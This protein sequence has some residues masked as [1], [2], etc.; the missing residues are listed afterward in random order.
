MLLLELRTLV[1]QDWLWVWKAR[2][3]ML[4]LSAGRIICGDKLSLLWTHETCQEMGQ[5]IERGLPSP[6]SHSEITGRWD[7]LSFAPG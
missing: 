5:G 4:L 6:I 1:M 7:S 3:E 2:Q